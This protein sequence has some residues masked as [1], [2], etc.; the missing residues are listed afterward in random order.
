[1]KQYKEL[2]GNVIFVLGA[3]T[4]LAIRMQS[5]DPYILLLTLIGIMFAIFTVLWIIGFIII[6]ILFSVEEAWRDYNPIIL[7]ESV[8]ADQ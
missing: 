8:F 4:L 5:L 1:M 3:A 2:K 7:L 6:S